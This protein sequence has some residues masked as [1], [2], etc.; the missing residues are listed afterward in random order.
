MVHGL[1][2]PSFDCARLDYNLFTASSLFDSYQKLYAAA[3][4][5]RFILAQRKNNYRLICTY[6]VTNPA[7][8]SFGA[9]GISYFWRWLFMKSD[10]GFEYLTKFY[11]VDEGSA[12]YGSS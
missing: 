4:G 5:F 8:F 7:G 3:V 6:R 1:V 11:W 9:D 10:D 12:V 2:V